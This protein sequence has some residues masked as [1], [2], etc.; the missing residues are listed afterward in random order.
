MGGEENSGEKG[1]CQHSEVNNVDNRKDKTCV[2]GGEDK[3]KAES[4][5]LCLVSIY[6]VQTKS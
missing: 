3:K 1:E 2:K 4:A 6:N 5:W